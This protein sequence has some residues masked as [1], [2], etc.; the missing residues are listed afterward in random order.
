MMWPG[1]EDGEKGLS[2][3]EELRSPPGGRGGRVG[4]HVSW[5]RQ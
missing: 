1:M 4:A 3:E 2:N 5:E